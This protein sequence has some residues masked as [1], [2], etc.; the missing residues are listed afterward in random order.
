MADIQKVQRIPWRRYR[1]EGLLTASAPLHIG[2]GEEEERLLKVDGVS[3]PVKVMTVLADANGV[4]YIPGSTIKGRLHQWALESVAGNTKLMH[5]VHE[6]FGAGPDSVSPGEER[7]GRLILYDAPLDSAATK[8]PDHLRLHSALHWHKDRCTFIMAS[9]VLNRVTRTAEKHQL[10]HFEAL[11]AGAAFKIV[12]AGDGLADE[13]MALLLEAL[14]GFDGS[15]GSCIGG[16]IAHGFGAMKWTVSKVQGLRTKKQVKVW[17]EGKH[18]GYSGLDK[19]DCRGV[20]DIE[21]AR[22]EI[23]KELSSYTHVMTIDLQ[24]AFDGPFMINDPS[25]VQIVDGE[26]TVSHAYLK[27]ATGQPALSAKSVRG[28][29]RAQAERI[30]RTLYPPGSAGS[31]SLRACYVNSR[32]D[33]CQPLH[34][35]EALA[36][37]CLTCRLFGGNGW[38]SPLTFTDF[39]PSPLGTECEQ[40]FVAIDRFTGGASQGKKFKAAYRYQP[41]FSGKIRLDLKRI[42]PI[43]AGLLVLTL[44]DLLEG[45][46]CLGFGRSKGFGGCCARITGVSFP[47]V[48]PTWVHELVP[49]LAAP[50]TKVLDKFCSTSV[51]LKPDQAKALKELLR[52]LLPERRSA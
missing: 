20:K 37:L 34:K 11:P 52:R 32:N 46:V 21:R 14:N 36:D 23:R 19:I 49:E 47:A 9:T 15:H 13:D 8:I 3:Q 27:D 35:M 45:D 22:G 40:E 17:L 6:L 50:T 7:G 33:S 38:R 26:A 51:P 25:R 24:V 43:H 30:V 18:C 5:L 29:L 48:L 31:S 28:A 41:H 10:Y 4:P 1:I 12:M 44:K 2:S 42:E 16:F 39:T